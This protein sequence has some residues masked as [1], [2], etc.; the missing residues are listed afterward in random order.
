MKKHK[1]FQSVRG[2]IHTRRASLF[3]SQRC[4]EGWVCGLHQSD[5]GCFSSHGTPYER[6][7]TFVTRMSRKIYQH[8][9]SVPFHQQ[10]WQVPHR[11]PM[12]H[13]R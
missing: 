11:S 3:E 9:V 12:D 7:G 8:H 1:I 10:K 5:V 4:H 13:A 6:Y 2:T